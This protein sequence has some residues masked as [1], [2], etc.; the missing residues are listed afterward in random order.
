MST[1]LKIPP[2][3]HLAFDPRFERAVVCGAPERAE[4]IASKLTDSKKLAQNREYS[5]F[6]GKRGDQWILVTSHGVGSAGAAICF[7]ELIAV[8][9]K[10][11]I[12]LGTAGGLQDDS[13]IGDVA[14]A[15][16]AIREDGVSKLMIPQGFPAVADPRL[17]LQLMEG[18][19]KAGLRTQ[20]GIV[21]SSDIFYPS[22][23]PTSLELYQ[24]AGAVAVEMECSTLFVIASLKR[25]R[26]G[27]MLALDGNPLKWKEGQYDPKSTKLKDS[28][29][30]AAD[31]VLDVLA[32][33]D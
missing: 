29:A 3:I 5:S 12:R 32:S 13:Q 18:S 16:A 27:A 9:V 15:T 11:I 2:H 28:I 20:A 21:L 10:T 30:Q 23:L 7:N 33:S 19:R 8:G 31:V 26:A 24:K 22:L 17:A 1:S 25:I 4:M 6:L 14:V